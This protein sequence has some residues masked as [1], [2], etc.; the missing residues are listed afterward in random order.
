M[1]VFG[2]KSTFLKL[3]TLVFQER[4][5]PLP[6]HANTPIGY[7]LFKFTLI[8]NIFPNPFQI[9]LIFKVIFGTNTNS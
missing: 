8:I 7:I 5:L 4:E 1:P 2:L 3:S 9:Y 6:I